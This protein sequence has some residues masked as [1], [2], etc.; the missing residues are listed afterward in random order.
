MSR[1]ATQNKTPNINQPSFAGMNIVSLRLPGIPV[2]LTSIVTTGLIANEQSMNP[3]S[4][5]VGI[6][7]FSRYTAVFRE[8]RIDSIRMEI[9]PLGIYTGA[10]YFF[11]SERQLTTPTFYEAFTQE[12][13]LLKNNEQLAKNKFLTWKNSDYS[14]STWTTTGVNL[15][16]CFFETYTDNANLG[17]PVAATELYLLRPTYYLRFRGLSST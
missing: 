16:P 6:E 8:Y 2:K 4:G 1:R 5:T 11:F 10:T 17:S 12:A 7:T 14:D 9:I 15:A 3:N 13:T